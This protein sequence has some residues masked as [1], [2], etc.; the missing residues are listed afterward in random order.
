[1]SLGISV[2]TPDPQLPAVLLNYSEASIVAFANGV[3][4]QGITDSYD[5]DVK[6]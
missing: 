6:V 3:H 2:T 1:M 5:L 4:L